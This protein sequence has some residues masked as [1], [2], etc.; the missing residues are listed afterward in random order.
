MSAKMK[1]MPMPSDAEYSNL[2]DLLALHTESTTR[3]GELET[4][5]QE[6][7]LEIVDANRKLYAYLQNKIAESEMGIKIIALRHPE[8]FQA[9]KTLKTPY[10]TVGFRSTTKLDV[11]NEEL[12]IALIERLPDA[13]L[14]LRTRKFLNLEALESLED[15]ALKGLQIS[16]VTTEKCTVTPAKMDLG[17]AVKKAAETE[18]VV[19]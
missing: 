13:D 19:P 9:I 12:T 1:D 4:A 6:A 14:Y 8:W 16:R 2:V 18:E 17:K 3:M 7:Y 10:G 11:A 15:F 5:V